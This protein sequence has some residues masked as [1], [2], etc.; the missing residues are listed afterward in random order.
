MALFF[1]EEFVA[2]VDRQRV[3][4]SGQPPNA[5]GTASVLP[6]AVSP[7]TPSASGQRHA[8]R[9]RQ[10]ARY[11]SECSSEREGVANTAGI[12]DDSDRDS[13]ARSQTSSKVGKQAK[14]FKFVYDGCAHLRCKTCNIS[15]QDRSPTGAYDKPMYEGIV[16]WRSYINILS[17]RNLDGSLTVTKQP[18]GHV[19]ALCD[20][21]YSMMGWKDTRGSITSYNKGV[22]DEQLHKQFLAARKKVIQDRKSSAASGLEVEDS[23]SGR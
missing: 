8:Q 10:L 22:R 9:G 3:T 20:S 18:S 15:C 4:A 16:P 21:T 6:P 5:L 2:D 12:P 7:A 19:C 13:L 23:P 1:P 17:E 11:P 14:H